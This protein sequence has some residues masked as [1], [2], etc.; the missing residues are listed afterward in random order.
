MLVDARHSQQ[1][2]VSRTARLRFTTTPEARCDVRCQ[3]LAPTPSSEGPAQS[4]AESNAP[5]APATPGG[6]GAFKVVAVSAA[7]HEAVMHEATRHARHAR[8][9]VRKRHNANGD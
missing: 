1:A 5:S 3:L 8:R 6:Q 2:T 7:W 9:P 4:S